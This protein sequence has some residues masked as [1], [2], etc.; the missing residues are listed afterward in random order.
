LLLQ[1]HAFHQA[2]AACQ[3]EHVGAAC[4]YALLPH[5]LYATFGTVWLTALT[6]ATGRLMSGSC[7]VG[8]PLHLTFACPV[9][10]V[11]A[12]G[13]LDSIEA[14]LLSSLLAVHVF[15]YSV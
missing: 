7:P 11:A 13:V 5:L 2:L 6:H 14:T 4:R 12:R 3:G 8:I 10:C 1:G 9:C 15:K